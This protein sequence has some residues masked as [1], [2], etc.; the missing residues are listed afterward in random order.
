MT[1]RMNAADL[2]KLHEE[3]VAQALTA[4]KGTEFEKVSAV[5]AVAREVRGQLELRKHA[6][7]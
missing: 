6:G 5:A 4:L 1:R 3:L 7:V 2:L